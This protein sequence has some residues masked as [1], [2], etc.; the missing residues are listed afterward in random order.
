M[1]LLMS[2]VPTDQA[3]GGIWGWNGT[4]LMSRLLLWVGWILVVGAILLQHA[5]AAS[6]REV[7]ANGW[8]APPFH[9]RGY[10]EVQVTPEFREDPGFIACPPDFLKGFR[11][12]VDY[13]H[14]PTAELLELTTSH[15]VALSYGRQSKSGV[16][17]PF[18][19][20]HWARGRVCVGVAGPP[21]ITTFDPLQDAF[22]VGFMGK[23]KHFEVLSELRSSTCTMLV[24]RN[25]FSSGTQNG[26]TGSSEDLEEFH[27]DN[28]SRLLLQRVLMR[29]TIQ[30][31]GTLTELYSEQRIRRYHP[32]LEFVPTEFLA[33]LAQIPSSTKRALGGPP[34][35]EAICSAIKNQT[36]FWKPAIFYHV[37]YDHV[38]PLPPDFSLER[39]A[40]QRSKGMQLRSKPL[41]LPEEAAAKSPYRAPKSAARSFLERWGLALGVACLAA[42]ATTATILFVRRKG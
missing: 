33:V 12:E 20:T 31:V 32:T 7:I 27:F 26:I 29:I 8:I 19:T 37:I 36:P 11:V 23:R 22:I 34:S 18:L 14:T 21:P 1:V 6:P 42:A 15:G 2:V 39:L 13:Y 9:A 5:Q 16:Q 24:V 40:E 28:Q 3:F 25:K 10:A 35:L 4:R 38:E 41:K 30:G 17:A